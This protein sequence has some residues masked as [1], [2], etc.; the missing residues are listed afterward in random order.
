[1]NW[2]HEIAIWKSANLVAMQWSALSPRALPV[3]P[4]VCSPL[5]PLRHA[6]AY[7]ECRLS[8]VRWKETLRTVAFDPELTLARANA[9]NFR[10]T[11]GVVCAC[12]ILVLI[13]N[14]SSAPASQPAT[15]CRH[16]L[17]HS[18]KAAARAGAWWPVGAMS[19]RASRVSE[20]SGGDQSVT[21]SCWTEAATNRS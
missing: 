18:G 19:V 5:A 8:G 11:R 21:Q 12:A 2:S 3:A 10:S 14:S 13:T 4:S 6:D 1:M 9:R 7:E 15:A 16:T 20:E 17:P